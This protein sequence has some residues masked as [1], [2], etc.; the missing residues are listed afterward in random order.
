[1]R[2]VIGK[3]IALISLTAFGFVS[4]CGTKT[5]TH[6]STHDNVRP[7]VNSPEF[8]RFLELQ[9]DSKSSANQLSVSQSR[10]VHRWAVTHPVVKLSELSK[11]DPSGAIGFCFGRAMAVNLQVR[12]LGLSKNSVKKLFVIGDLRSGTAPEWRF[13]VTTLVKNSQGGWTAIDPILNAPMSANN[14]IQKVKATWDKNNKAFFYLTSADAVLPDIRTFKTPEAEQGDRIIELNFDPAK[15]T[16]FQSSAQFNT[17]VFE[18]NP[19]AEAQYF[20]NTTKE[21]S[22][23]LDFTQIKINDAV[24]SYNRY[25]NDLFDSFTNVV[26]PVVQGSTDED[27]FEELDS[28][29]LSHESK[30]LYSMDFSKVK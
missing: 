4:A 24:F 14:W 9:V 2:T 18:V 16:G 25:F 1:M 3:S 28:D 10:S 8:S 29:F 7:L 5:T 12:Q 27:S 22:T 19:Q 15:S 6:S 21:S 17:K 13:H 23:S 20:L 11:Y 30:N 26:N